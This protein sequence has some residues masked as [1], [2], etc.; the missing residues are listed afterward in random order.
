[1]N[2][3]RHPRACPRLDVRAVY[4]GT[5]G[6]DPDCP[7][8]L[9]G[10]ATAVLL[11]PIRRSSPDL[12]QATRPVTLDGRAALTNPDAAVTHEIIDVMPAAGVEVSLSYGADPATAR[13]I[14]AS[15]RVRA[16]GV[17]ASGVRAGTLPSPAAVPPAPAQ[18]V[19]TGP[20][21]DTCAAPSA[22]TMKAWLASPYRA[23]GHLHRRRQPGLRAGQ[24][25]PGLDPRHPGPGLALLPAVRRPAGVLRGSGF[26]DA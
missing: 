3:A 11:E 5:P 9:A 10:K 1:M 21:F 24:P 26:G 2:L 25:D 13:R 23:V 15:V 18:G 19:V 17:R 14:S 4:L 6:P 7:A 12:R 22:A 8:D 20:G 16:S